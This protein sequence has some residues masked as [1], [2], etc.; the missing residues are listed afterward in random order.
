MRATRLLFVSLLLA[1]AACAGEITDTEPLTFEEFKAQA[2]Q[3]PDTGVFVINGD[4]MIEDEELLVE[5]YDRYLE[6]VDTS[7]IG[8]SQYESIVNKRR[9]VIDVWAPDQA[10]NLTFCISR[11]GAAAF[12]TTEYN[13][14]LTA[15]NSATA[16]WEQAANVDFIHGS[17]LKCNR[18]NAGVV[19]NV[20]RV[21]S[22]QFLASA[23]F[24]STGRRN[25][26]LLIDCTSFGSIAPFTLAGI[27]R[28]ERGHTIGLRHE[29]TRP[30][31]GVC[32]EDNKW[33]AL[34]A[35]D[36]A[37]VMHYPQ[38]NGTQTGDLVLTNLDRQGAGILYP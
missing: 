13:Q 27:L 18:N 3:N 7:G 17:D 15:M 29:H 34:T 6:S 33:A 38:C 31:S 5:A 14:V 11:T 2:Y 24:P 35:Y 21:C 25:R 28:H 9:G 32:F 8:S 10:Q 22:G 30:E 16:T 36:S 1:G 4:E 20:S 23:F 19:F 12:S 37:S 26:Q